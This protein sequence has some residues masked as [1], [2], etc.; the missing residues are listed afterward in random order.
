MNLHICLGLNS[1]KVGFVKETDLIR[2]LAT[3]ARSC[4]SLPMVS[5][6][7][8]SKNF[9]GSMKTVF[10]RISYTMMKSANFLLFFSVGRLK[11]DPIIV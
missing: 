1:L 2:D 4:N 10:F 5:V 8:P 9:V 11:I 3:E 6:N 7:I